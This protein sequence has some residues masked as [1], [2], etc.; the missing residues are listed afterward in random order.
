MLARK[1]L[2]PGAFSLIHQQDVC[3]VLELMGSSAHYVWG[4]KDLMCSE[5]NCIGYK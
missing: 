2:G 1:G 3:A 5:R 4:K